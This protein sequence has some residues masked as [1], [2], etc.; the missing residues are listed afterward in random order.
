[1][2]L[3]RA[4]IP[5]VLSIFVAGVAFGAIGVIVVDWVLQ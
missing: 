2:R 5:F 1:M 3:D 4:L